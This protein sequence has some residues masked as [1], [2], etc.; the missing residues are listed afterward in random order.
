MILLSIKNWQD[1]SHKYYRFSARQGL[2]C[3][4]PESFFK[5]HNKTNQKTSL[6]PSRLRGSILYAMRHTLCAMRYRVPHYKLFLNLEPNNLS[7]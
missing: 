4:D 5:D 3:S 6:R 1:Y 7:S 2:V